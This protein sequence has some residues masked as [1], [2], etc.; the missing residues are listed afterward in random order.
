[1][2]QCANC[3]GS[4]NISASRCPHCFS[5]INADNLVLPDNLA[6]PHRAEYEFQQEIERRNNYAIRQDGSLFRY[7]KNQKILRLPEIIYSIPDGSF[8]HYFDGPNGRDEF[9]E[10]GTKGFFE[11]NENIEVAIIPNTIK[12]IPIRAF[13]N[14][15]HLRE[16]ILPEG[17]ISIRDN[18]FYGCINLKKSHYLIRWR[19]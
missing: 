3:G 1:M 13:Q 19:K 2:L 15:K 16:V 7:N 4:I 14:C 17:L 8:D 12:V 10:P 18:A 5:I 9:F 6:D 11:N